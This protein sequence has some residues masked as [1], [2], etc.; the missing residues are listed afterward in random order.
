MPLVRLLRVYGEGF[1]SFYDPFLL[2]VS[3]YEGKALQIDGQ[4]KSDEIARSNGSGK[5]GLIESIGYAWYGKLGRKNR[6]KDEV[7]YNRNG[8]KAKAAHIG[9]VFSIGNNEYRTE[10]YQGKKT[11]P[12][13][14]I[15]ENGEIILKDSTYSVKQEYLEKLLGMNSTA[16]QCSEVFGGPTSSFL[17]FPDLEPADRAKV[18]SD[19]RGLD[20]W[21]QASDKC[22]KESKKLVNS[23]LEQTEELR[24][25]EGRISQLREIDY[26]PKV[27]EFEED[28]NQKI[29]VFE[30]QKKEAESDLK[31]EEKNQKEAISVLSRQVEK[32]EKELSEGQ[33]QLS[34]LPELENNI[35]ILEKSISTEEANKRNLQ[36]DIRSIKNEI[37]NLKKLGSGKCP[38]CKQK[39]TG[40][41]LKKEITY[42]D[43]EIVNRN[44]EVSEKDE[45]ISKALGKLKDHQTQ[46]ESFLSIQ[47]TIETLQKN[48]N[49]SKIDVLSL[50]KSLE[51]ER[52]RNA[53]ENLKVSLEAMKLAN[54]P[55]EKQEE[56]RKRALFSAVR[57]SKEEKQKIDDLNQE[58]SYYQFWT[59]GF[60][61]IRISLFKTMI[62]RFQE[63]AQ[64]LLS[65]YSSELQVQFSTVRETRS[66]TIKDEFDIS[67]TDSSG[68]ILSW[69]MYS[70]G[71]KQK[72]R[73]SIARALSQM[74]KDDCGIEF[75]FEVFDEPNDA[76]D[77]FGRDV[78]FDLFAKIAEEGKC[79]LVTDHDAFFKDRFS[80]SITIVKENDKSYIQ[81]EK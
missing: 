59:E 70:G 75:N 50:G 22:G 30:S 20:K 11:S 67:I 19:V 31:E 21:I 46:K 9:S 55:Y 12:N 15:F 72:T 35:I 33:K 53:L 38:T 27:R 54:N 58:I 61:K 41:H 7:I 2:E 66:G 62:D 69:E 14:D 36:N 34:G 63:Y 78:N 80:D 81:K 23:I 17:C 43:L 24:K 18:L 57:R 25:L 71:E 26:K 3:K 1:L 60:K 56:E 47:R 79:V 76:L 74:I 32:W 52:Q 40:D 49:K 8:L 44:L 6:Y 42:L 29:E 10:R 37:S 48:I 4:N 28:R 77:S 73:L 5:S 13:L 45:A 64:E 16:F 68:T 51:I 39:I 65:Q